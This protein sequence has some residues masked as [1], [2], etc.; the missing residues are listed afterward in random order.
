MPERELFSMLDCQGVE[1]PEGFDRNACINS[2]VAAKPLLEDAF[3]VPLDLDVNAQ[4]ATFVCN[5]GCV[6]DDS[7]IGGSSYLVCLTFSNFGNLCLLWGEPDWLDRH[8]SAVAASQEV[9]A[10]RG[11][12][13][14]RDWEVCGLYDG[15]HAEWLGKT[16]L[17][18][19]FAHY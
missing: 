13:V 6:Q 17:D 9:L 10:A 7:G 14:V 16:W 18:R 11:F 1:W 5:L 12:M 2:I 4:D 15:C 3:G 19:F 8:A